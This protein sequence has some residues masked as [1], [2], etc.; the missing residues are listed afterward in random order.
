M[1]TLSICRPHCSEGLHSSRIDLETWDWRIIISSFSSLRRAKMQV[2][3]RCHVIYLSDSRLRSDINI[4]VAWVF[5]LDSLLQFTTTRTSMTQ[6]RFL[7]VLQQMPEKATHLYVWGWADWTS[8]R[9]WNWG[10]KDVTHRA[11]AAMAPV[12]SVVPGAVVASGPWQSWCPL[13]QPWCLQPHEPGA[14]DSGG[15]ALDPSW[16]QRPWQ[17]Q[18]QLLGTCPP[19]PAVVA[20]PVTLL[21][22]TTENN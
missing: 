22:D 7:C 11:V 1:C 17:F 19:P 4:M 21:P 12:T 5:P 18:E 10:S 8:W 2:L 9:W 15:Y 16:C 6:Q 13:Q 14:A 20:V 3:I